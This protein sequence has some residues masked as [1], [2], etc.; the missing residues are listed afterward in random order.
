MSIIPTQTVEA[1]DKTRL[2]VS[3]GL[4]DQL[5][6]P[7]GSLYA[8]VEVK[9]MIRK[10]ALGGDSSLDSR[11][12]ERECPAWLLSSSPSQRGLYSSGVGEGELEFSSING[13][14]VVHGEDDSERRRALSVQM[15]GLGSLYPQFGVGGGEIEAVQTD[16]LGAN[17]QTADAVAV[18]QFQ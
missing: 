11:R 9:E 16:C 5:D 14:R 4:D 8:S 6:A 12:V 10:Q 1:I 13:V 2:R 18:K 3:D 15:R 7:L 17:P